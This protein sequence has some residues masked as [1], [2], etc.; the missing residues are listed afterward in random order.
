MP[1]A[2]FAMKV[3]GK[4]LVLWM[5]REA[6]PRK[7]WEVSS[8]TFNVLLI[9]Y[10]DQLR[11]ST[12]QDTTTAIL[13]T[14]NKRNQ[15]STNGSISLTWGMEIKIISSEMLIQEKNSAFRLIN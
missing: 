6:A 4:S 8:L 9:T 7:T 5:G 12:F 13:I 1:A 2:R 14:I 11:N 3:A 15:R 10:L